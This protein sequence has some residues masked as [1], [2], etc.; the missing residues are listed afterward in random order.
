MPPTQVKKNQKIKNKKNLALE[1]HI[2]YNGLQDATCPINK[3]V[4][5]YYLKFLKNI[6]Q[7]INIFFFISNVL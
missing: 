6:K 2:S 7:K 1:S 3:N 4:I 5:F